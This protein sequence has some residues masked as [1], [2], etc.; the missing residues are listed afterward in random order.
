MCVLII[1][2]KSF[3]S[4]EK[5]WTLDQ[6]ARFEYKISF[7]DLLSGFL[8]F[9]CDFILWPRKPGISPE[10]SWNCLLQPCNN[11][12]PTIIHLFSNYSLICHL[13]PSLI[14]FLSQKVVQK[15]LGTMLEITWKTPW[16]LLVQSPKNL[17]LRY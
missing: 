6:Y 14:S 5:V 2:L 3:A 10:I 16:I 1:L 13:I 9:S 8:E 17:R 7:S 4:T 11:N 12:L 15:S